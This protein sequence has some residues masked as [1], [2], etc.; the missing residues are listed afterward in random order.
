[1]A[2]AKPGPGSISA[3]GDSGE[4]VVNPKDNSD[5]SSTCRMCVFC[6]IIPTFHVQRETFSTLT[7]SRRGVVKQSRLRNSH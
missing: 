2:T 6:T 5:R 1:M 3:E 7:L 4:I